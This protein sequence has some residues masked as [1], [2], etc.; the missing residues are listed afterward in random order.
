MTLNPLLYPSGMPQMAMPPAPPSMV[1]PIPAPPG[2]SQS[3]APP[4]PGMPPPPMGMPPRAPYGP[5]MGKELRK[6]KEPEKPHCTLLTQPL[7]D[8]GHVHFFFCL[9][10]ERPSAERR[11]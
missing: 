1:P 2:S 9:T 4:P 5:P 6:K 7:L 8:L 3:R 11:S 10:E